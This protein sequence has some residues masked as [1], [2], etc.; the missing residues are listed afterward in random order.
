MAEAL[1]ADKDGSH[2]RGYQKKGKPPIP[3]RLLARLW[4][5]RATRQAWFRAQDGSRFRVIYPGREGKAAGPDF[6]NALV[7]VEGVGLVQGDVEIH[8]RQQDWKAHGHGDDPRYNGVILHAALEVQS[9]TTN[10]QS[11]RAATVVSLAPLLAGR[12]QSV[13]LRGSALWGLLAQQGYPRPRSTEGIGALLDRAGDDRFADKSRCYQKFLGEQSPDQTLYEGLLEGLGYYHNQHP[14]LLLAQRASYSAV[15]RAARQVPTEDRAQA[16]EGWLTALSGLLARD[17]GT[18]LPRKFKGFGKPL[19]AQVWHCFRVRPANH[20]LRR[21][22]GAAGLVARFLEPGLVAGLGKIAGAGK[23]SDLAS[24]LTVPGSPGSGA[25]LVGRDR[26]RDLAVNVVLPFLHGLA[27]WQE[28]P[29]VGRPYLELYHRF[30]MLQENEL[31]R[32][33]ADQLLVPAWRERVTTARRQQGLLHL[34]H[35]LAGIP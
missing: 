16:I 6:R 25:A 2:Y 9:S 10:L 22:A 5:R 18:P 7:E 23:P 17:Q 3:E 8:V 33:M 26:A 11:G 30:G 24:A 27:A 19:T 21:I 31:T 20:P 1:I 12:D 29:E 13:K 32:E 34:Q 35:L 15:E 14:F 4:Q 28:E